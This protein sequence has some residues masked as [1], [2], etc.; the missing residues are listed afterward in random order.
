MLWLNTFC[1]L[2][3]ELCE[4]ETWNWLGAGSD[5]MIHWL[6]LMRSQD[7][8]TRNKCENKSSKQR[9]KKKERKKL[10]ILE[11]LNWKCLRTLGF[12]K[13]KK[14]NKGQ[15]WELKYTRSEKH[16][17]TVKQCSN[18]GGGE[19]TCEQ[20]GG[21]WAQRNNKTRKIK[22]NSQKMSEN[23]QK[24]LFWQFEETKMVQILKEPQDLTTY[25]CWF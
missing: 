3:E 10:T 13:K 20:V 5:M 7:K 2:S 25:L 16:K 19:L 22:L 24:H 17:E 4:F 21:E 9:V 1:F 18:G 23:Q 8:T 15:T 12:G 11:R 6:K 14:E